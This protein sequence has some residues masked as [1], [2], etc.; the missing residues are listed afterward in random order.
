MA[1]TLLQ[2]V[3]AVLKKARLITGAQTALTTLTVSAM[4]TDIDNVISSIN[5]CLLDL[6]RAG[7]DINTET[8]GTITLA[9]GVREYD[10]ASNYIDMADE[11]FINET[12]GFRITPYPG[13][14]HAMRLEQSI[15]TSYTGLPQQWAFNTTNNK[16]RMDNTPTAAEVGLAYNYL[17]DGS[18]VM[19]LATDVF[20][21]RDDAVIAMEDAMLQVFQRHAKKQFDQAAY[22]ISMGR[23][24]QLA[25]QMPLKTH[26]GVRW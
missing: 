12:R 24:A 18:V 17:Y 3:N 1:K 19:S 16:F 7:L 5:I 14:F 25:A 21:L 8:Q 15:P 2:E 26:Y 6:C 13:G 10:V 11:V 4:Q 23:A 9:L 20:P 22:Q